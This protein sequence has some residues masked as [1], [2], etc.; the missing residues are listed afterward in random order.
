MSLV[1]IR[2]ERSSHNHAAVVL[3]HDRNRVLIRAATTKTRKHRSLPPIQT[4]ESIT[5]LSRSSMLDSTGPSRCQDRSTR[6]R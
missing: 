6:S 2:P 5:H 3:Q 4:L 1:S